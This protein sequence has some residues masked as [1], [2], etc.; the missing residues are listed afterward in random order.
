MTASTKQ[1]TEA[2]LTNRDL[3]PALHMHWLEQDGDKVVKRWV[4]D[5]DAELKTKAR[6]DFR[7]SMDIDVLEQQALRAM[8]EIILAESARFLNTPPES[9]AKLRDLDTKIK[10]RR[11]S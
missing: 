6:E 9:I 10:A 8:R 3:Q 1:F 2:E 11:T 7:R 5:S 4:W